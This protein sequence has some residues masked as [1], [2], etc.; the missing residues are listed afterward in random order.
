[1]SSR[2][3]LVLILLSL[4]EAPAT[5]GTKPFTAA[6]LWSIPSVSAPSL[7]RDGRLA[8]YSVSVYDAEENKRQGDLW[9]VPTAG[10]TPRRL[11][12]MLGSESSPTFS[13]D[14]T[15]LAFTA[16][17]GADESA[18][19]Y[20]LPLGG[21]EPRRLTDLPMGAAQ[22]VW[23][24]DGRQIVFVSTVFRDAESLPATKEKL[25]AR[26]KKKITAIASEN[27][28]YRHWDKWSTPDE[29][30]HLFVVDLA[31]GEVRD[32]MPGWTGVFA[33]D[34]SSVSF[35]VAPDGSRVVFRANNTLP[36]YRTL[37]ADLF[38]VRLAGGPIECLTP[39]NPADDENPV[40]SPDGKTI[41]FGRSI[42]ADG[43]PDRTRLAVLDVES[44]AVRVLTEPLDASIEDWRFSHDGQALIF[45]AEV[46]ARSRLYRVPVQGGQAKELWRGG[47]VTG[48]DLTPSGVVVF[49]WSSLTRPTELGR[50]EADGSGLRTLT[51]H[52]APLIEPFAL[53][54]VREVT[55]KGAGDDQVQMFYL[56]PPGYQP[57]KQ[58]P[59]LQLIHGGPVGTFGDNWH[60]RW[61]AQVFCSSTGYVVAMVN[62]HGSSSFGQAFLESILG[63]P[64]DK[65]YLDV[66]RA[67]DWLIARGIVDPKR[68]AAG[69][70]SYGGYLTNFI[71]GQ[72]GRFA[73][74]IS[75]AGP[76]NLIH[77]FGSDATWGRHHSYGGYPFTALDQ[78]DRSSPNRLTANFVTPMLILHGEQ[79]YR[80]PYTH[81]LELH[82][83]L[84]AKGVPS[85]LVIYPDENHWILKGA[86]SIEWYREVIDWLDRW[87]EPQTGAANP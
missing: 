15:L 6:E 69:G 12:T 78:I 48:F 64:A 16:K 65:P 73:A 83:T 32:L 62:F 9:L 33:A 26:K 34:E 54:T 59:L 61:N 22:P 87:L 57:G 39:D 67:T 19:I 8:V 51:Q 47:T 18:Q 55:F 20:L 44:Q 13:P 14:G 53:G 11:T 58:Y 66:M 68:M 4:S 74:L 60:Q 50:I 41:A 85:R 3:V 40:F 70:G 72:T 28:L 1:M 84:T 82:G 37:N 56:E 75:H 81:S 79:D 24:Q 29:L 21:G 42:R 17:R 36:P 23:T 77:Q 43:W 30:E 71:A 35:D 31:S 76:Y 86:N 2:L 10:G 63:A 49:A 38:S 52:A 25:E 45:V 80:V 27:R 7:S 46:E 5:A